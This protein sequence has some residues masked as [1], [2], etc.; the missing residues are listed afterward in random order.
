MPG[1]NE[2][3][4]LVQQSRTYGADASPGARPQP[5]RGP[6]QQQQQHHVTRYDTNELDIEEKLQR[7]KHAEIRRI[8]AETNEI[9]HCY[10]DLAA[11]TTEQQRGLDRAEVHIDR[12]ADK[13]ESGREE[14][15][16]ARRQQVIGRKRMCVLAIIVTVIIAVII[17]V[18]VVMKSD[19]KK[20]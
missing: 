2:R 10:R 12:A 20:K 19:D 15:I 16:E 9:H 17:I 5:Q 13:V 3:T 4:P 8:E 6:A 1:R 18:V 14:L 11:L 7:E